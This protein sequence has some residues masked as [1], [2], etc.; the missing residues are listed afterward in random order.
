[1]TWRWVHYHAGDGHGWQV[2]ATESE[3]AA[4]AKVAELL[5]RRFLAYAWFSVLR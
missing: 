2:L 4:K 1:M 5:A 3:A